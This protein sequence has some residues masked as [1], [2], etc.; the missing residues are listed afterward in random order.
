M[1][2]LS[3]FTSS[4]PGLHT[5]PTVPTVKRP[6]TMAQDR[7]RS[8]EILDHAENI[9]CLVSFSQSLVLR[10]IQAVERVSHRHHQHN[11]FDDN[12]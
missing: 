6:A 4:D 3:S 5:L 2:A 10:M 1:Y 12:E 8:R 7:R 11:A 9:L